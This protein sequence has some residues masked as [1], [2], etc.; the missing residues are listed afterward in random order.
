MPVSPDRTRLIRQEERVDV[1][2]GLRS[3]NAYDLALYHDHSGGG[4]GVLTVTVVVQLRFRRGRSANPSDLG[5]R[6]RWTDA[7]K[8]DYANEFR[9]VCREVWN[10]RFRL[11]TAAGGSGGCP[12]RD[13]GVEFN[14]RTVFDRPCASEHWEARVVRANMHR[15]SSVTTNLRRYGRG[16][17]RLDSLDVLYDKVIHQR[18]APHEFGHMLGLRDEYSGANNPTT[19]WLS[20]RGSIMNAGEAVR[21]RHYAMLAEWLTRHWPA[22]PFRVNGT[23]DVS[24]A[25]L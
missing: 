15:T 25:H 6:L 1:P 10:E 16:R 17:A 3:R 23:T 22:T 19:H 20:D 5:D 8:V 12:V 14:I 24:N 18:G 4:R 2:A 13:V 9:R 21:E 7:Q 11:T